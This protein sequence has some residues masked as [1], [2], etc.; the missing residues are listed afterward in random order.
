MT[1]RLPLAVFGA[2]GFRPGRSYELVPEHRGSRSLGSPWRTDAGTVALETMTA[3]RPRKPWPSSPASPLAIGPGLACYVP[4]RPTAPS[5]PRAVSISRRPKPRRQDR[6]PGRRWRASRRWL[7]DPFRPQ[8]RPT[9]SNTRSTCWRATASTVA[10]GRLHDAD[11]LCARRGGQHSHLLDEAWRGL[12]LG[13]RDGEVPGCLR[14]R[15]DAD[16]F[17]PRAALDQGARL[18]PPSWST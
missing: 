13:P 12:H 10:P 7:E 5:A 3:G 1:A 8:D 16:R 17:S 14:Q 18:R 4:A 6:A 2:E 11:V 15:Q 9:T